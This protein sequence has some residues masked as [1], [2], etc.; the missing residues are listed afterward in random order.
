MS[1]FVGILNLDGAPVDRSLL[2]RM[3]R[4]L[5]FRGPD[6]Q[7]ILCLGSV[8][9][10]HA[11]LR[12]T[13]EAATEKQPGK[14][15]DRLYVVADARIDARAELIEKLKNKSSIAGSLSLSTPDS[16][17]ILL[18]Y[19]S[20]GE[21]CVEHLI[22]DF[23]FAIWDKRRNRLL[24]ARDHF[25]VKPFFYAHVGSCLIFSNTLDCIRI[26]PAVSGVL[27]DLAIADFLLFDSNQEPGTTAFAEIRRL[28]P[29]HTLKIENETLVERRYW[30][31]AVTTPVRYPRDK[32]Y[33]DRF[34]E[35]LDAAVADRWR[36]DSAAVTLSGGLDSTTVAASA[37]RA[38][39]GNGKS[40]RLYAFTEVFDRLIP[41][42][43]RHYAT[44]SAEAL[45]IPIE[46]FVNDHWKIFDG[47]DKPEFRSPEPIHN[48]WP[49]RTRDFLRQ[50]SARSRT[51]LTGYG[52]DPA[53]LGRIT[54]HFRQLLKAGHLGRALLD[55]GRY[56]SAEGRLSRLYIKRRWRLLFRSRREAAEGYPPWLSKDFEREWKLQD[57]WSFV[58]NRRFP[59]TGV[60]PEAMRVM[61][62]WVD[63]FESFDSGATGVPVEVCHPFYD[64]RLVNFLLALPRLPWCCDK[65]L[66]R[67]AARGVLPDLVRL[68]GK[69]PLAVEPLVAL[70]QDPES[71]WVD[72][73]EPLPELE[74]F[75]VRNRIP[76]V[77]GELDSVAGWLHLKPLSLNFWLQG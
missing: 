10:G 35:L 46:Y 36:G 6:G 73:F 52:A 50:I 49:V 13:R 16:E 9:L 8:G 23:S 56:L 19:D 44:L 77:H 1:G 74:R 33:L 39:A 47:A 30:E 55:A 21:G 67:E 66:L 58:N 53:L 27:N 17:L 20:W 28:P 11:M 65:E 37:R 68:R 31:L 7:E 38:F 5:A 60:R 69:S 43:E 34:R 15:D 42:E 51:A 64:L 12:A 26:H 14:V 45:D 32:E 71:A 62:D 18:A 3:T 54:V 25:G 22:G 41:H 63:L 75:V 4:F 72:R 29:A 48:A 2:E 24:C 59:V 70:L 76:N 57:R 61:V 40:T